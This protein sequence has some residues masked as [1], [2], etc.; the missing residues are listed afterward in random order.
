MSLLSKDPGEV[1]E[2]SSTLDSSVKNAGSHRGTMEVHV[3]L[4]EHQR[5][6]TVTSFAPKGQCQALASGAELRD[7]DFKFFKN[8]SWNLN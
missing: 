1:Q 7:R 2:S 3:Y 4:A 6:E 8:F 5:S